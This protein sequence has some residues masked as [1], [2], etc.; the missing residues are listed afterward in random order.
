MSR[1]F[2]RETD[3]SNDF[4]LPERPVSEHP[5]PV[6]LAG[7]RQIETT[8]ADLEVARQQAK[9][10]EEM[11]TLAQIERDLRYWLQ[12]RAS[13]QVIATEPAPTKVRFGVT[14]ALEFVDGTHKKFTLV[15]EDQ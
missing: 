13:A 12:R 9:T 5:N 8:I 15:G 4:D 11:L 14:V 1:A 6:T 7:L 10:A 3:R 2:V